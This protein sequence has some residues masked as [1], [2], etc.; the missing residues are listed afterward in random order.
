[1]IV[2]N[3][4]RF[5]LPVDDFYTDTRLFDDLLNDI[6]TITCITHGRGGTR[7]IVYHI[8]YLH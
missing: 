6:L 8:I 7:T 4:I 1:M 3:N 5:F 2:V